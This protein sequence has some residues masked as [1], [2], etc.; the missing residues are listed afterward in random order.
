MIGFHIPVCV[1]VHDVD[2]NGVARASSIMRYLQT[3]AQ[4]QLTENGMSYNELR[5]KYK[6]GFII[7]K[8]KIEFTKTLYTYDNLVATTFPCHSRG[9]SFLRCYQLQ[10]GEE[11]V[12][13]AISVWALIDTDT[14][15]LVRVND[16]DYGLTEYD[17]IDLPMP[18]IFMPKDMQP[19]GT[20]TVN[21]ADLDQNKHMNN[22]H[23]PDMYANFLPL[24]KKRIES[25]T[26]SYLNEAVFGERLNVSFA[27]EN[28]IYYIRTVKPDGKINSEAE[29]TLC[30][31]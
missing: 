7:S 12:A 30:D 16:F 26:I 17:P 27:C 11:T 31:I 9:Y 6:K 15:S 20:Y 3:A 24:D 21:Y 25:I 29:I 1:D 14:H 5:D 19:C 18:R 22:T 23:Y 10:R 13:R 4:T 28:G 2:F 8:I